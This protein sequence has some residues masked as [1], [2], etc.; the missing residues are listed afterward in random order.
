VAIPVAA[1]PTIHY[2]CCNYAILL[3]PIPEDYFSTLLQKKEEED[4]SGFGRVPGEK[5]HG[6]L[7]QSKTVPFSRRRK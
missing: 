2:S 3:L 6:D 1:L 4:G 5:L 7:S